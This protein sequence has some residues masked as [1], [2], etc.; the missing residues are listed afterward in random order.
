MISLV[1]IVEKYRL[2]PKLRS[3]I[4]VSAPQKVIGGFDLHHS[5][6]FPSLDGFGGVF[7]VRPPEAATEG[8]KRNKSL[9]VLESFMEYQ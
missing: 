3:S 7:T 1:S 9:R 6:V 2:P 8:T 4:D 5:H